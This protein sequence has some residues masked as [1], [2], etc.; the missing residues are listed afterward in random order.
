M[1]HPLALADIDEDRQFTLPG[2]IGTT[3]RD[4]KVGGRVARK[5]YR[6]VQGEFADV[7][8]ADPAAR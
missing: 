3:D 8:R 5:D 7:F 6:P 2:R 1:L 4:L